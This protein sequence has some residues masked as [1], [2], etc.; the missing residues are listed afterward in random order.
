MDNIYCNYMQAGLVFIQKFLGIC[1][2]FMAAVKSKATGQFQLDEKKKC[3]TFPVATRG[4]PPLIRAKWQDFFLGI[5][6]D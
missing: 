4:L 2:L 5:S 6:K 1:K 3:D